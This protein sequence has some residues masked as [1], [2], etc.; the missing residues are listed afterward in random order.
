MPTNSMEVSQSLERSYDSLVTACQLQH[1][2]NSHTNICWQQKL[3]ARL[4]FHA[5]QEEPR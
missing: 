1:L 2:P 3:S 5:S 4:L